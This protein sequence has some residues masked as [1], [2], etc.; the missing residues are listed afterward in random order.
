MIILVN[1]IYIYRGVWE[2]RE[3]NMY[4]GMYYTCRLGLIVFVVKL[5]VKISW[6][7]KIITNILTAVDMCCVGIGMPII[8][9]HIVNLITSSEQTQ[10]VY[11]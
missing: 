2:G 10:F 5:W 11:I 3:G 1:R 7:I 6:N 9:L 4:R 8:S